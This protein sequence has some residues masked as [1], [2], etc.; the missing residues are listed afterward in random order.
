MYRYRQSFL[1]SPQLNKQENCLSTQGKSAMK[2]AA[3][4]P[5]N[6]L[7]QCTP[8]IPQLCKYIHTHAIIK[9]K[10]QHQRVIMLGFS[11]PARSAKLTA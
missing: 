6:G 8:Q 10:K 3:S 7:H 2:Q 9:K 5:R 4:N 1:T 11:Q